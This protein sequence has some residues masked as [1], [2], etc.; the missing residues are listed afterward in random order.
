[1]KHRNLHHTGND[2]SQS[3]RLRLAKV[4][5]GICQQLRKPAQVE[6]QSST[7]T[8]EPQAEPHNADYDA[9]LQSFD[10]RN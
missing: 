1:M 8:A 5:Q 6:P 2:K 4:A 10:V 9:Y 7:P 3:E